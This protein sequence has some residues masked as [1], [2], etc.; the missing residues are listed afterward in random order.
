MGQG[1]FQHDLLRIIPFGILF[2]VVALFVSFTNA[3]VPSVT[4]TN[5]A[6]S[7]FLLFATS[8]GS[9]DTE[10]LSPDAGLPQSDFGGSAAG[11]RKEL[12]LSSNRDVVVVTM[13]PIE[14]EGDSMT[15]LADIH[16]KNLTLPQFGSFISWSPDSSKALL[17][18]STLNAPWARYI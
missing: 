2:S 1:K 10:R 3:S 6:P 14:F 16:G 9:I 4:P 15:Y 18:V 17:Y 12:F 5:S 13:T 7:G 11:Y 8:D